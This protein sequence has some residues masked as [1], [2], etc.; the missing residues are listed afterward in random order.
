MSDELQYLRELQFSIGKM[1][2]GSEPRQFH[3]IED[4][5]R[6]VDGA[7]ELTNQ[8]A[9]LRENRGNTAE[10]AK[11]PSC[12]TLRGELQ[13]K[14]AAVEGA[15]RRAERAEGKLDIATEFLKA[16]WMEQFK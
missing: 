5:L 14:D 6:Y 1:I 7:I 11:C 2:T 10:N 13:I 3:S 16:Q 12:E 15:I 4:V 8:L 9:G